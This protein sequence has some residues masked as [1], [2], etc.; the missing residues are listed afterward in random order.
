MALDVVLPAGGR[1]SG[2]FAELAGTDVKALIKLGGKSVVER[3]VQC[4]REAGVDGRMVLVGPQEV[5]ADAAGKL[6]DAVVPEVG[7]G[8][9]NIMA[10]LQ[11]LQDTGTTGKTLI[12]NTDLPFL[13]P[14]SVRR[15]LEACPEDLDL[16]APVISKE[17]FERHYPGMRTAFVPLKDGLYTMGCLFLVSP[18]AISDNRQH[19]DMVFEA[20]KSQFRMASLLGFGF[21]MRFLLHRL[22]IPDIEHRCTSMLGCSVGAVLTSDANLAFDLDTQAEC[23]YACQHFISSQLQVGE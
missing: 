21:V 23:E 18:T 15:F 11:Y 22:S 6:V 10:G 7:S 20:R 16:C 4:L 13:T 8:P 5:A 1:I 12:A 2:S 14:E 17:D 19:I 3:T 9:D